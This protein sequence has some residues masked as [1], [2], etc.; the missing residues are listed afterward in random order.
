MMTFVDSEIGVKKKEEEE[1]VIVA[2]IIFIS[3]Q[4][5]SEHMGGVVVDGCTN[6]V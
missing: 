4:C 6:A 1:M 2:S 5:V 3:L